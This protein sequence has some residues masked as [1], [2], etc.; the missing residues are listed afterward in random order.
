MD[1]KRYSEDT[2]TVYLGDE[3]DENINKQLVQLKQYL[4]DENLTGVTEII[5]S[6]TSLIVNFDVFQ[7][8][9]DEIIEVIKKVDVNALLKQ[10][11]KY[12][13]IEI[14]VCY[15]GTHGPDLKRFE[16]VGLSPDE[17]IEKHSEKEYL[18]YMLGFMPGFPYLGG[19]DQSL[20]RDRLENPRKKVPK[21]A[22]GIGGRQTGM[23]PFESPGGW[24]LLGNTPIPL[25]DP[26]RDPP[27]LYAP[28]DRIVFKQISE[29]E[30]DA[31]KVAVEK[32]DYEVSVSE[33]GDE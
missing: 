10:P 21:G 16:S 8:S 9:A 24:N 13:V 18:V 32:N 30:Y 2:V 14:P 3:I 1:I 7:T 19:L 27:I 29:S 17:V 33:G 4:E 31:L 6:Y 11:F 25:F 12:R 15:G 20:F 22:V 28:G 26:D 23:Y 5:V